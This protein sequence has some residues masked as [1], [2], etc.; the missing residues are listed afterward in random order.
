MKSGSARRRSTTKKPSRHKRRREAA[1]KAGTR[2]A[3]GEKF[4]PF[5][6]AGPGAPAYDQVEAAKA[7][8]T[9]AQQR[10]HTIA[11]R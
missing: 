3:Q 11:R 6:A 2:A 9:S 1:Q 5:M 10:S 7:P 8:R 4:D